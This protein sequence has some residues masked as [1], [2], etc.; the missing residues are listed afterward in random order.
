MGSVRSLKIPCVNFK[1]LEKFMCKKTIPDNTVGWVN[2]K[3]KSSNRIDGW[4]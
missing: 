1:K 2:L 3:I 4:V